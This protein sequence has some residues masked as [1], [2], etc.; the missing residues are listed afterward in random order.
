MAFYVGQ[1]VV[2]LPDPEGGHEYFIHPGH[3]LRLNEPVVGQVYT[4]RGITESRLPE[5]FGFLWL[6]EVHNEPMHLE[7][8]GIVEVS[9]PDYR[10]RP[11]VE[12]PTDISIFKA[13]LTPKTAEIDA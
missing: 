8:E 11:V 3:G 10:F 12:R 5:P 4:I 7:A 2:A 9:W 13:M 6:N 1:K